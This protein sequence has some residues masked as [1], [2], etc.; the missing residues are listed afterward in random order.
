MRLGCGQNAQHVE[1][2]LA[3][4]GAQIP[5]MKGGGC[6]SQIWKRLLLI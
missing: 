3:A 4:A 5:K 2:A 1:D 6:C